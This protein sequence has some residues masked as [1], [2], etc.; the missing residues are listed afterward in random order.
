MRFEIPFREDIYREK[1]KLNFDLTWKTN[2]KKNEYSLIY[3]SIFL[4]LGILFFL[5]NSDS[6]YLTLAVA[7]FY[8]LNF[9]HYYSNY[10]KRKK[11]YFTSID[12]STEEYLKSDESSIWDFNE[13]YFR[14]KD[15]KFDTKII[16]SAIKGFRVI[17]NNILIHLDNEKSLCF[18]LGKEE[19]GQENF[20][21]IVDF[22]NFKIKNQVPIDIRTTSAKD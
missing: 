7:L 21:K 20:D 19:V 3:G 16:W 6:G 5:E 1:L 14:F 18:I 11:S 9:Y 13:D 10:K 15:Y 17:E 4:V 22:L 2:L 12:E 8:I